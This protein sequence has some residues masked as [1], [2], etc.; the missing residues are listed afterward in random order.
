MKHNSNKKKAHGRINKFQGSSEVT[1][2]ERQLYSRH[3]YFCI[4]SSLGRMS[5]T[6]NFPTSEDRRTRVCYKCVIC[7]STQGRSTLS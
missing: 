7:I 6:I 2:D 1:S 3:G 5:Q 4:Q